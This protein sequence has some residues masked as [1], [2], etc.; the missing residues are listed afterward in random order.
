[1][2]H[3]IGQVY[4]AFQ[5]HQQRHQR[6][7]LFIYTSDHGEQAGH[8]GLWGKMNFYNDAID[9][10]LIIAGDQVQAGHVITDPVSMLDIPVTICDMAGG[11]PLPDADGQ[12]LVSALQGT[13]LRSA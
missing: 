1:M 6:Q 13:G 11:R 12:S 2:T 5:A 8:R 9:I 7:Q 10:P 3:I 4:D